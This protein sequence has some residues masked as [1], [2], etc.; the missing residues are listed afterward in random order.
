MNV[1][2]VTERMPRSSSVYGS[3][4]S[5]WRSPGWIRGRRP[6]KIVDAG[7]ASASVTAAAFVLGVMQSR[8]RFHSGPPAPHQRSVSSPGSIDAVK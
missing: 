2:G 3:E 8:H 7:R 6:L 4:V 5:A 1:T